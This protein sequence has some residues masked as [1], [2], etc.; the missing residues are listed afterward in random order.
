MKLG[1]TASGE[2]CTVKW[3][4]TLKMFPREQSTPCV[5][6]NPTILGH[7]GDQPVDARGLCT[8]SNA[9]VQQQFREH[10]ATGQST[11]S[12]RPRDPSLESDPGSLARLSFDEADTSNL[13]GLNH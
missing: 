1:S 3:T 13:G 9:H 10:P 5:Q 7:V 6:H 11:A 2:I 4:T 12:G 8:A